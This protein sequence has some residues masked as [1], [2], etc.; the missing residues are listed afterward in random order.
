MNTP[1]ELLRKAIEIAVV[2]HAGQKDKG[3]EPYVG[4]LFR[5][6]SAG[7]TVEEKIVGVL[8]DL[9]EDTEWTP[10]ALIEEQFPENLVNAIHCLSKKEGE[11]YGIYLQ[12]VKSNK[13]SLAVKMNDLVD[14]MD[15]RRLKE[16]RPDDAVRLNK[17]LET[18]RMLSQYLLTGCNHIE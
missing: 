17:Y 16:I 11:Y 4:H 8:H 5:V 7:R 14:N 18:Y 13:L 6:M 1:E 3:G 12:R 9:L 2:A 10:E 15:I